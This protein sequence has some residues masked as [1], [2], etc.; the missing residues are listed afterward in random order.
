[1]CASDWANL[2]NDA[3]TVWLNSLRKDT[4]A[5]KF[6]H[7][8]SLLENLIRKVGCVILYGL[9]VANLVSNVQG[10][11]V[12][13]QSDVCLLG[14]VRSNQSVN[15]KNI[16]LV[17]LLDG[18]FDLMLVRLEVDLEHQGVGVLDLLHG[19]L[20]GNG[21]D[22]NLVGIHS[23]V[24]GH[25]LSGVAWGSSQLQGLGQP[26]GG[27]SSDLVGLVSRRTFQGALLSSSSFVVC[28][29]HF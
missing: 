27:A 28:G 18:S 13:G 4:I 21:R 23:G 2:L 1:M 16:D 6:T 8:K 7:Y 11:V 3:F 19:G 15:V 20:S 26:E 22:N 12:S 10:I 29:S 25:G 5:S 14:T 17:Q 9:D 24:V